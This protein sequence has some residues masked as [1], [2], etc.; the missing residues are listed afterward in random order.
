MKEGDKSPLSS[1]TTEHA[2]RRRFL[3]ASGVAAV[4]ALAGC[5]GGGGGD[6]GGDGGVDAA[7]TYSLADEPHEETVEISVGETILWDPEGGQHFIRLREKPEGSSWDPPAST[8]ISGDQTH[9]HT[10]EVAGT[11]RWDCDYHIGPYTIEVSE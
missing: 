7:F 4:T 8:A 3:Q 10:F 11:Y 2:S 5:G 1:M 6:S 9:Q